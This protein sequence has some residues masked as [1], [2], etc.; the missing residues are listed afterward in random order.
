M[1]T[2]PAMTITKI[3]DTLQMTKMMFVRFATATLSELTLIAITVTI[4]SR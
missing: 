2:R 3:V 1:R 4:M